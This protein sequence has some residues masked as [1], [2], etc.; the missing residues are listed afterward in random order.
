[1]RHDILMVVTKEQIQKNIKNILNNLDVQ[2]EDNS[3]DYLL[4]EGIAM[5]EFGLTYKQ[6]EKTLEEK[7]DNIGLSAY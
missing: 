5:R 7:L 1:M 2:H 4:N 6:I 3:F